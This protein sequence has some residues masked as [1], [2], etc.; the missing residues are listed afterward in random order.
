MQTLSMKH[1]TLAWECDYMAWVIKVFCI[2]IKFKKNLKTLINAC[3]YLYFSKNKK[4][5]FSLVKIYIYTCVFSCYNVNW[6]DELINSK[7]I[8]NRISVLKIMDRG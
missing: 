3:I 6:N 5:I 8:S 2:D 1:T 4:K 7:L